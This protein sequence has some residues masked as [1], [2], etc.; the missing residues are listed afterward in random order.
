MKTLRKE[1]V[2]CG[3]GMKTQ[4]IDKK[5]QVYACPFCNSVSSIFEERDFIGKEKNL[6]QPKGIRY[7]YL[8]NDLH[9]YLKRLS[10]RHPLW[11]TCMIGL[12]GVVFTFAIFTNPNDNLIIVYFSAFALMLLSLYFLTFHLKAAT[13]SYEIE[14][15]PYRVSFFA[16]AFRQKS[17]LKEV[18]SYEVDRIFI[19]TAA[20]SNANKRKITDFI[21]Q[22]KQYERIEPFYYLT[23]KE[24]QFIYLKLLIDT[25]LNIGERA[26]DISTD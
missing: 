1:C 4:H 6:E 26:S 15:T 8:A 21:I 20:K 17:L 3:E 12:M 13:Q 10:I 22:T 19:K 25:Y 18:N 2:R 16:I 11:L 5:E 7:E 24:D 9:I 23:G 14:V